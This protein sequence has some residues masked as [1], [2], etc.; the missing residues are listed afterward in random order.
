MSGPL[1]AA[2]ATSEP[3]EY[4]TLSMDRNPTGIWTQRSPLRDADVPYL[5]MKFYSASRF[6]SIIDGINREITARLTVA[7][8]PG[9]SPYNSA[10][11]PAINSFYSYRYIQNGNEIVRV[12]ADGQDGNI[13]D[14]TAGQK[15]T[16]F[17]KSA[18]TPK[19]RFLGVNTELFFTNGVDRK[20]LIRSALVWA[21]S[22]AFNSNAFIVDPNL[23]LQLAIGSQTATISNIQIISNVCTLFFT[24]TTPLTIP[25]G[26]QITLSAL[27]AVPALNG[28]TQTVTAVENSL[29]IT[30][31][32]THANL[33]YAVETGAATT[34]TGITGSTGPTWSTTTGAITIDGG[35]QWE[36]RGSSVQDWMFAAPP[37]AP[38]V[39][40]A[41]APTLYPL[42]AASTWYAP[43][44]VISASGSLFQLTTPG[45]SGST[46]PTWNTTIG[47]TTTDGSA[48]W[49][50]L[51]PG[52]WTAS[53]AYIA[54]NV[55]SVTFTYYITVQVWVPACFTLNTRVK[56]LTGIK[57]IGDIQ[58]GDWVSNGTLRNGFLKYVRVSAVHDHEYSG[59]MQAMGDGEGVT[60][61]H[62]MKNH[63]AWIAAENL[64][65]ESYEFTG[66][67]R[68]LTVEAADYEEQAFLLENGHIAHNKPIGGGYYQNQQQ[69]QTVTCL[70]V[71]SIAG[72][73]GTTAPTWINGVGTTVTDGTITWTNQGTASVWPG[74]TQAMSLATQITGKN[75]YLQTATL[76]GKSGTTEPAWPTTT[77]TYTADNA[78][79]WLDGAPY[80]AA[81]TGAWIY[82]YSGQNSITKDISTASPESSPITPSLGYQ[83]VLQAPG[84]GGQSDSIVIWRTAQGQS[85]LM[86]LDTI[87]DPGAG[88]T[89]VYTDTTPDTGLI[90]EI[91]APIDNSNDPPPVGLSGPVYHLERIW[92]FVGNTVYYSGGPDTLTG[93]GNTSWPPLNFIPY[94]EKII[95]LM[96]F[97]VSN[98]GI[99]VF[100][101]SNVYVILGTGTSSNGFYTTIYMQGVGLLGYDALDIVGSTFYLMTGKSKFVSLDPS[102][103]Y[104]EAGFPIGD[105]FSNV[106]TGAG[107]AVTGSLYSPAT[108]FVSWHEQSSGDT[109]IYVSD[110]AVGWFRFSP[111]ASPE[112]GYLWSPRAAIVG[113]TSAVQSVET[114]PGQSM[115]LIGPPSGGGPI[116]FRDPAVNADWAMVSGTYQYASFPAWET[117]GNIVLCQSGEIA[118]IAHIAL[119]S[120]AIGAKPAVSLLLGEIAATNA[121]PFE[122]LSITGNDPPDLPASKTIYSDRYTALQNGICPKCDNFQMKVDYGRQNFPDELLM[123]S[124]YGAKHAERKQQ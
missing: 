23:N 49:T 8:R 26:V 35:A 39:T 60:P 54:G 34:G 2:G 22:S 78:Q 105:Q 88:N 121:T 15:T 52:T 123:F 114:A 55:V 19:T 93:S 4:A 33:S 69:A 47:T 14:A 59:R 64:F 102:A 73:S 57:E 101:T 110:G 18:G 61:E 12:I 56:T 3:S 42:W 36:C 38:T 90:P 91:P 106:T 31:P 111:V 27:T 97:T 41:P 124:V 80:G 25:D 51:G 79:S 24:G 94:P 119:K 82:A 7:R 43:L 118:E 40:Q 11:F 117:K 113:G 72:T 122:T 65:P 28:T 86:Y 48:V 115:L 109:A 20:K 87:P 95:R 83:A 89:W 77:G 58:P 71:C 9:S 84:V 76:F 67:V 92:G 85:T 29:Q 112:S 16:L 45:T 75:G 81:N 30:F 44:F 37:S 1:A 74:A 46:T 104:I 63:S 66:T 108:A 68:T 50:C 10:T 116:L 6:D 5:Q 96:P 99:L 53:H 13:Y 103:G 32:F 107:S 98:G 17:T 100:T 70:F 120:M 21:A 62:E